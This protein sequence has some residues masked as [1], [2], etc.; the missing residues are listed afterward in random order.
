MTYTNVRFRAGLPP[1]DFISVLA[2]HGHT[3]AKEIRGMFATCI[4][5]GRASTVA[6]V[7]LEHD[8]WSGKSKTGKLEF[9]LYGLCAPCS[10]L[11]DVRERT[12]AVIFKSAWVC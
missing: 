8:S 3:T 1:E 4:L 12:E 6:V 9:L 2:V 5:C 7:G 10:A 11:P